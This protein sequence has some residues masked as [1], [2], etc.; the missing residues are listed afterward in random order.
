MKKI[1]LSGGPSFTLVSDEDFEWLS[2]INWFETK[3]SNTSYAARDHKF[4]GKY[5]RIYLHRFIMNAP[6]GIEVDHIN[7]NGLDNRRSNLRLVSH[8]E[9]MQNQTKPTRAV[10]GFRGVRAIQGGNWNAYLHVIENGKKK[11]I[12]LGTWPLIELAASA[13]DWAA[14][15][16]GLL[17]KPNFSEDER[18]SRE[19][20]EAFQIKKISNTPGVRLKNGRYEVSVGGGKK[21]TYLGRFDTE[22]E[23]VQVREHYLANLDR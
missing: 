8:E 17:S 15:D 7:G 13:R 14:F 5:H 20:V 19:M 16:L 6:K 11:Q 23:A 4:D 10:S 12:N 1:L 22:E 2:Q 18:E 3:R 21:K 9:N